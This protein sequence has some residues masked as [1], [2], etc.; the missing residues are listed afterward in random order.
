VGVYGRT[1]L[2]AER[3][4][5]AAAPRHGIAAQCLRYFNAAGADP[6]LETGEAHEPETHV[7]PLLLD[8]ASG[9]R[10]EFALYGT[11]YPTPDGTCVRDY[12]H[13]ADIAAAHVAAL[14]APVQSGSVDAYNLGNE[15]GYSVHEVIRSCERG[16]GLSHSGA[17]GTAPAG[18]RREPA[19]GLHACAP[20]ARLVAAPPRARDHDRARLGLAS[21]AGDPGPSRIMSFTLTLADARPAVIGLGYVGLPLAIALSRHFPTLGF[22]VS[23]ARVLRLRDGVDDS[24]E[25]DPGE[26]G[27]S[28]RVEFT[29]EAER[30]A[31]CNVYIVAVPTPVTGA[32]APGPRAAARRLRLGRARAQA[33]RRGGVRVHG[34]PRRH[35]RRCAYR[36]SRAPRASVATSTS[37]SATARSASTPATA[38]AGSRTW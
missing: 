4:I 12:L 38:S 14:A 31:S 24:G 7:I 28:E 37:S 19:R 2:L 35:R 22:D 25:V 6:E 18:R 16:D 33:R 9:R 8:V 21:Q 26:L 34:L 13:V 17:C 32:Q 23:D 15:R 27:G 5:A 30:L 20:R 10:S 1:K 29:S 11:D 36:C 3:A